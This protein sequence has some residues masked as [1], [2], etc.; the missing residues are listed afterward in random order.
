MDIFC[1]IGGKGYNLLEV[2]Q[3]KGPCTSYTENLNLI[4][5][6]QGDFYIATL[7]LFKVYKD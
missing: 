5:G 3:K 1:R 6:R 7:N 4:C 2:R